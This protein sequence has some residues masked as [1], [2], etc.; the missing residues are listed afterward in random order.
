MRS[1]FPFFFWLAAA[2]TLAAL[3]AGVA[4]RQPGDERL[5]RVVLVGES[6]PIS[7]VVLEGDLPLSRARVRIRGAREA[8]F[9]DAKGR[10][11]LSVPRTQPRP[12][13]VTAWKQGFLIGGE[14][15][16]GR[17]L[18]IRLTKLP[19]RDNPEYKWV[20]PTPDAG[21]DHNCGNCHPQIYEEWKSSGHAH[22]ATNRRFLNLYDGSDWNGHPAQGWSLLD[23]YPH[24][25]GVCA[26]CHAPT[27]D[28]AHAAASDLR[29]IDGVAAHGVHCDFCH[30]VSDVE[31]SHAGLTHGRFG[32]SLLRPT[33]GQLFFG[34]LDD[35][36]R[37]EDAFSP[38]QTESRYCA[39][40]HEG[41]VFGVHVYST[42]S[43]WLDSPARR[44]GRQCQSCH[45]AP[46]GKMSNFAPG[47]G[48]VE[49]DPASL[50]SHVLLPGGRE[51][52]L[53]RCLQVDVTRRQDADA[54]AMTVTIT[55]RNVG[56]RVPTGFI[57]RHLILV[58]DA[59]GEDSEYENPLLPAAAGPGL[60]GKPGRLFAKL[61]TDA[62]GRP[63]PFW[64][65]VASEP[66]DSRLVPNQPCVNTFRF[67]RTA[68]IRVRLLYRPFWSETTRAKSWPD[69]T[70]VVYDRTWTNESKPSLPHK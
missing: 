59:D 62:E 5:T 21:D 41:V 38:L 45:M 47:A 22:A 43:E 65:G 32:M 63:A 30:K 18:Q 15:W 9:T 60:A 57:D 48:G 23:E 64:R 46:T 16:S 3:L 51:A 1:R 24:G 66:V 36:P 20:D 7:G 13:V 42:Y 27:V 14:T 34:P 39:A 2:T 69:A 50:A 17:P 33:D 25:A 29:A 55:A 19:D 12:L 35:V 10:F 54:C 67:S 61:L 53:R 4:M 11:F 40:C 8:A 44:E 28:F 6:S 31:S 37:N 68:S 52:M 58:V 70:V 49:R 56:H 26:A